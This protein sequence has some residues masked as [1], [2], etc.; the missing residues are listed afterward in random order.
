MLIRICIKKIRGQLFKLSRSLVNDT[1]K[2]QI[3]TL[4]IHCYFLLKKCENLLHCK[5]IFT[6]FF[7][8]KNTFNNVFAFEVDIHS[9]E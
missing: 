9:R 8:T 4:Q 3:T 1:L 7:S 5:G 2:F 6:F